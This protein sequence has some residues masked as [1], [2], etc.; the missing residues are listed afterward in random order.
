[1]LHKYKRTYFLKLLMLVFV[2]FFCHLEI[3]LLIITQKITNYAYR[4]YYYK[5]KHYY[6]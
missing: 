3:L 5:L 2:F 4:K 1:M 6:I